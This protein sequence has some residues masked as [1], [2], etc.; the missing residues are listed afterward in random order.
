MSTMEK[1]KKVKKSEKG[2]STALLLN[3]S[4]LGENFKEPLEG[5]DN[6]KLNTSVQ[7]DNTPLMNDFLSFDLLQ[8][9]DAESPNVISLAQNG[10]IPKVDIEQNANED[11]SNGYSSENSIDIDNKENTVPLTNYPT[12]NQIL[13]Q[14]DQQKNYLQNQMN[15]FPLYSYYDS[16]SKYL[17]QSMSDNSTSNMN[18]QPNNIQNAMML[19]KQIN[20]PMNLTNNYMNNQFKQEQPKKE[21][22]EDYEIEMFGRIGW[23]CDQCNNFNYN[24][25]NK[26][27]RCGIP[28]SPKKTTKLKKKMEN[29]RKNELKLNP[30]VQMENNSKKRIKEREGDWICPNCSNLNFSFRIICNRCSFPKKEP[31]MNYAQCNIMRNVN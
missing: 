16:T 19:L 25:R 13:N 26:C 15:Q 21:N 11:I 23:I 31:S 7:S 3:I 27:N 22:K 12:K 4:P 20:T 28:K 9:I 14:L 10:K 5:M 29:K 8:R 6:L 18:Y 2:F 30:S 24:T 1:G 17:S